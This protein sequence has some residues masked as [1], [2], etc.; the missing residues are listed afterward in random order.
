MRNAR[1]VRNAPFLERTAVL[2][3]SLIGFYSGCGDGVSTLQY[4]VVRELPHDPQAYT[5]GLLLHDGVLFESTGRRGSSSVRKVDPE[6][7]AVLSIREL[8][9]A[10][11][12]EGLALVGNELVQL[13]WQSG[14]AF[15]Y[16]VETLEEVGSYEYDG[17]GWGLC[18]D[19]QSLF[20]SD[21]SDKL[22]RRNPN[23]FQVE[24]EIQVTKNGFSVWRLNELE[25]VGDEIY[26]NVYQT[27]DIVRIDKRSGAVTGQLDA[28][29]LSVATRRTTDPEA[30]LNGI[31]YDPSTGRFY[32]TGKLW[33]ILFEIEIPNG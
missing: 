6:S 7:G 22:R 8:P 27:N 17:E 19:G 26:A 14:V 18:F 4:H 15:V 33:P 9:E 28:Y 25:C 21:G 32:L 1:D 23:T 13:T 29:G 31:A 5:Q 16:D 20:M 24:E 30:V 11:F 3:L 12:G 10:Y 2:A